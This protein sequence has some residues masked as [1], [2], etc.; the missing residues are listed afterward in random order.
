M[1]IAINAI[2]NSKTFNIN[3]VE[4]VVHQKIDY[5]EIKIFN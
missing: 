3:F 5:L 2:G 4:N 1:F